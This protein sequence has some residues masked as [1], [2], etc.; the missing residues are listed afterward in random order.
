MVIETRLSESQSAVDLGADVWERL[1]RRSG[2]SNRSLPLRD[3]HSANGGNCLC[4]LIIVK[5]IKAY[6]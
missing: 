4:M 5:E 2:K 6:R 1:D 3:R